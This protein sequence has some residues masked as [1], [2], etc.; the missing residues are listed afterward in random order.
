MNEAAPA[1]FAE[2]L[3][4]SGEPSAVEEF[5][6]GDG[7]VAITIGL[8]VIAAASVASLVITIAMALGRATL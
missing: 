6:Y 8:A 2:P 4:W 3:K 5:A 7:L 1:L